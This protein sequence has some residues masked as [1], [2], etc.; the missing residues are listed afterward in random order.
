MKKKLLVIALALLTQS[1][2]AMDGDQKREEVL[3]KKL[4]H[5]VLCLDLKKVEKYLRQGANPD[6]CYVERT[7]LLVAFLSANYSSVATQEQIIRKLLDSK[8]NP[9]LTCTY[10]TYFSSGHPGPS[11]LTIA[12][13]NNHTNICK[14]LLERGAYAG[15]SGEIALM[16]A[17]INNNQELEH[18]LCYTYGVPKR[19]SN[20]CDQCSVQ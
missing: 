13:Q 10:S 15:Y 19:K 16:H 1:I 11:A 4:I 8:A 12:A 14:M 5:A 3:N 9:N 17:Q 20:C 6:H 2:L 18:L 7:P